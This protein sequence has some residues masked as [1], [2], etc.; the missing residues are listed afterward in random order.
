MFVSDPRHGRRRGDRGAGGALAL[1]L[2]AGVV[3]LLGA[4]LTVSVQLAIK[5]VVV[6]AADASALAAANSALGVSPGMP[7]QEARAVALS[8]HASLIACDLDGTTVTVEVVLTTPLGQEFAKSR[9]G[10]P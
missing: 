9:A 4:I 7:C 8:N 10:A 1:A 6:G 5:Q 2:V 3:V